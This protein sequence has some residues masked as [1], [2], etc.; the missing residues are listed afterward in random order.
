MAGGMAAAALARGLG[1]MLVCLLVVGIGYSTAQPGGSKLVSRWFHGR[2][3]GLAMGIRQAGLPL[4]GAMAAAF[5]PYVAIE[6]GWRTAFFVIAA[7][8]LGG[9]AAFV[10]LCRTAMPETVSRRKAQLRHIWTLVRQ[11]WMRRILWSGAALVGGQYAFLPFF[12]L[13]LRDDHGIPLVQ[14]GWILFGAQVSGM[15]GR[16]V[17][18][19][20]SDRAG[21]SRYGL[22]LISMAAAALG[23][24][25]LTLLPQNIPVAVLAA[26]AVWFG[27]FGLGWYGPWVAELADLAPVGNVGLAMGAAMACNQ[28]FIV[29]VPPAMGL[30]HDLTGG[31][32]AIW[33]TVGVV[34]AATTWWTSRPAARGR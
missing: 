3:L 14:A 23:M 22:V 33:C 8:V 27:F 18:A 26:I 12:M 19:A 29:G 20:W 16:I 11:P 15:V 31:Y 6:Y 32:M 9:G 2:H 5:L 25:L 17:L 4:G 10:T 13:S 21:A 30:V 1:M 7:T 24:V 28:L 34:L